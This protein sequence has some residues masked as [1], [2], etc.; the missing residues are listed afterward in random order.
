MARERYEVQA[1]P[2]EVLSPDA[3]KDYD[4]M[5]RVFKYSEMPMY[6]GLS[7]ITATAF[8]SLVTQA[9]IMEYFLFGGFF[10]VVIG[11][12]WMLLSPIVMNTA[13]LSREMDAW[14]QSQRDAWRQSRMAQG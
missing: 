3:R 11:V 2:P 8:A 9:A 13:R 14:Q 7:A 5:H 10:V 12:M 6:A 1:V 4:R